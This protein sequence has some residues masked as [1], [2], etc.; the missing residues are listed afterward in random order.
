MSPYEIEYENNDNM[1]RQFVYFMHIG[2]SGEC[3]YD[4]IRI[5]L[6]WYNNVYRYDYRWF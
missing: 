3:H 5:L 2:G 4:I 6:P 1:V